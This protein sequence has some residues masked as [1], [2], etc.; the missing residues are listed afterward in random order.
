ML[1][2]QVN[3]DRQ[4]CYDNTH[5]EKVKRILVAEREVAQVSLDLHNCSAPNK[6][7]T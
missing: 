5:S 7:Y 2:Y 3:D 1:G 4:Y 6:A